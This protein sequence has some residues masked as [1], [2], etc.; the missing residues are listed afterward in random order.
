MFVITVKS[1]VSKLTNLVNHPHFSIKS[2][3]LG[4]GKLPDNFQNLRQYYNDHGGFSDTINMI[5]N[6]PGLEKGPIKVLSIVPIFFY[7]EV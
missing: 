5:E 6:P 1:S 3:F 2:L 4:V 7:I